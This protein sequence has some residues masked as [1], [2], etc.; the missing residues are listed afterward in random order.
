MVLPASWSEASKL[1]RAGFSRAFLSTLELT[2]IALPDL[3][4]ARPQFRPRTTD[5]G[6]R[7]SY[8]AR[9]VLYVESRLPT[10]GG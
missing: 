4:F 10:S 5:S 2:K 8:V 7:L 1:L 6:C 3:P 9:Y